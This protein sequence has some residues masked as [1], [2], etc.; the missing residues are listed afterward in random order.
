MTGLEAQ[1]PVTA[2]APASSQME[3]L[4]R[5]NAELVAAV[6]ARDTF[7]AVAAHEL[8][9]PMQPIIGQIELLLN[10]IRAGRCSPDQVERRLERVQ[11]AMR[12]YMK[13]AGVLLDVSR[14]N[15]GKLQFELEEIDIIA[16]L[17]EVAADAAIDRA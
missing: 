9:N 16:L 13:R 8:R 2:A 1:R 12:H 10:G 5:R 7:I 4:Q 15:N 11:H 17:H 3:E 6:E 14:I